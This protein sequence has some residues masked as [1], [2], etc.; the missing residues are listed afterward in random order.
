MVFRVEVCFGIFD[1][2]DR[3]INITYKFSYTSQS[4]T[5]ILPDYRML[6]RCCVADAFGSDHLAEH[7]SSY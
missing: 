3:T 5:Q 1:I 7:I 6:H 2:L 4:K